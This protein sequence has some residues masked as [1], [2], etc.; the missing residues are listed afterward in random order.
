[1]GSISMSEENGRSDKDLEITIQT[2][3]EPW[4]TSFPKTT[5]V[6]AVIDATIEH[7]G[8]SKEGKYQ[9]TKK[10][11]LDNPLDPNQPLVSFGIKDGDILVFTDIGVAV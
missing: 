11:D 3:Q 1:M 7:F 5:K 10:E 2:T 8:F 4:E 9:L 6:Q